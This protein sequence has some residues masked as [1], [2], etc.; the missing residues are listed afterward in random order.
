MKNFTHKTSG[1]EQLP[2]YIALKELLDGFLLERNFEKTV[3]FIE[4]DF[5]GIGT[6]E[7]VIVNCKTEFG[8]LLK[9][10]LELIP[11]KMGYE[12]SSVCGKEIAD[13]IWNIIAVIKVF[14]P[15]EEGY[16]KSHI[17]R[18]TSCFKM[19]GDGFLVNSIH[20]SEPGSSFEKQRE[21]QLVFDII[22]KSMPGGIVIGYAEEGYPLYYANDRYLE[23]LGYSSYEEYYKE[24]DGLGI[25]HIHSD[26]LDMVNKQ[27]MESYSTDTQFGIEYRIRHKD[28]HYISVYDIGKKMIMPNGKEVIICVLYDMTEDVRMKEI[29]IH[30]SSYD[31]LTGIYNR[32]GGIRAVKEALDNAKNY[33]FAFFDLD[34]LKLL[35]DKYNH[36]VGDHALRFFAELL[37]RYFVD[38]T[39]LVRLGGDE[40]VAFLGENMDVQRVQR[41][42][43]ILE[44]EYCYF[45]DKNYPE[46]HSS[47]SIGCVLGSKKCGFDELCRTTDE[48][49]YDIKKHGKRG[50][51][52]VELD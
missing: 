16:E 28:G 25:K 17:I 49:M 44:Q 40:F 46:S 47:I 1:Y 24:A 38:K 18:F 15:N 36:E 43:T 34:N 35:N 12:I 26:D 41:I 29:L 27:I 48:L 52:I 7:D 2:V 37:V 10:E 9:T 42:F 21:A 33:C 8:E 14:F 51:K 23:L 20:M 32:S 19:S 22:S 50:Y 11:D 31:A 45:I 5:Y 6:H 13:N 4:D 39:I 30:E 3:S